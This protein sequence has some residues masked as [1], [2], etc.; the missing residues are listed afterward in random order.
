MSKYPNTEAFIAMDE[1]SARNKSF[2]NYFDKFKNIQIELIP[3]QYE[4]SSKNMMKAVANDDLDTLKRFI[5]DTFSDDD[6]DSLIQIL[7][8]DAEA[9]DE[10]SEQLKERVIQSFGKDFWKMSLAI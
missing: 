6:I 2:I 9:P 4:T 5:P 8:P 7:K 3:S 1:K 10:S